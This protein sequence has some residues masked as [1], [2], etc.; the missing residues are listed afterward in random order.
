[1]ELKT[2]KAKGYSIIKTASLDSAILGNA[3]F[4]I[5]LTDVDVIDEDT[6]LTGE[7]ADMQY[8]DDVSTYDI[9]EANGEL[10]AMN[11]TMAELVE[12]IKRMD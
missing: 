11:L 5:N 8:A 2:F 4:H 12:S 3:I 6:T 9:V 1:M 10:V 7:M